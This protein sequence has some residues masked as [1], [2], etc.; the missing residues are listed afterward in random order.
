MENI[1]KT[2]IAPLDTLKVR[3]RKPN[4]KYS[5]TEYDTEIAE[6]ETM[7]KTADTEENK[8][9]KKRG[10]KRKVEGETEVVDNENNNKKI[11]VLEG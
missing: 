8:D 4:Q 5:A 6:V 10:V 3:K 9:K 2:T 11:N 7:E 1:L